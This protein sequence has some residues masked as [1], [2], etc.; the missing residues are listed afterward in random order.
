MRPGRVSDADRDGLIAGAEALVFPSEYEG[1]G[2]PVLEAMALGTPVVCSDRAA[3]PEVAGDA[4]LVRPLDP[5]AWEGALDEVAARTR[6]ARRRRPAAGALVHDGGVGGPPRRGVPRLRGDMTRRP[7]RII[8]L[9]PHFEPDTAPTGR[10]LTRIVEELAA[11]ATSCTSC[12]RCRGTAAHAIEPGWGGR[13]IA[14]GGDRRGAPSAGPPVPRRRQA[15]PA[16]A[17]RRVRRV[18]GARRRGPGSAPAA[19]SGGP[20]P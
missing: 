9:G 3:L 11:R 13:L 10:V 18:L 5:D 14:P 12:P 8:V 20:T 4:A 1:F 7:L 16:A 6:R 19:G 17:R 15:Q 2:A